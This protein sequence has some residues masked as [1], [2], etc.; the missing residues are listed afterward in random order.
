[1]D[2]LRAEQYSKDPCLRLV[3]EVRREGRNNQGAAPAV[4]EGTAKYRN[5]AVP[6]A[7]AWG[8]AA[9]GMALLGLFRQRDLLLPERR[10]ACS[11][12]LAA[13]VPAYWL[14]PAYGTAER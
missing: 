7:P 1:M 4:E 6:F 9:A 3:R 8:F 5:G 14:V 2:R 10:W 11:G 13:L 12:L